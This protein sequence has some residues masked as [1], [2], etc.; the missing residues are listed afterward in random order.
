MYSFPPNRY[1]NHDDSA[2]WFI[3]WSEILLFGTVMRRTR[4]EDCCLF[5]DYK[6]IPLLKS[7]YQDDLKKNKFL[8]AWSPCTT[9]KLNALHIRIAS[10]RR[11]WHIPS[12]PYRY[13][14][15]VLERPRFPCSDR[16]NK[17]FKSLP[18]RKEVIPFSYKF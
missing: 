1:L 7:L 16:K 6:L 18:R 4:A 14:E 13:E 8:L 3:E 10:R 9:K 12:K 11:V 15:I 5:H 17:S 2:Y